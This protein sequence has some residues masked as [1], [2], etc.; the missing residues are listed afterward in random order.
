MSVRIQLDKPRGVFTNLDQ[1]SGVVVLS[2]LGPETISTITVKLEGESRSHLAGNINPRRNYDGFEKEGSRQEV[3]KLLY[4]VLTVFPTA[5]L[6]RATGPDQAYTLPSGPH[7]Y[8]F[9]FKLPFNNDCSN[10][11]SLLNGLNA[12]RFDMAR[13]TNNHVKKTLPPSLNGLP[14]EAEIL[15]YVKVTVQRPAFYKENFRAVYPFTFLPI[16]PPRAAANN[17]ESYARRSHQFSP[18]IDVPEKAGLFRKASVAANDPSVPEVPPPNISI[19][20]RLPDPAIITCNESLPLR[21]LIT[22]KNESPATIYLRTLSITLIGF[23]LIR[24]HDLQ[25][26]EA[27]SWV[28]LSQA[29][30]DKPLTSTVGGDGSKILEVESTLWKQCPLPSIVPPSFTTCNISRRYELEIKAGLAWGSSRNINPELSV[31]TVRMPVEVY[32]GIAPP[33]ALLDQMA[34]RPSGQPA[35]NSNLRPHGSV[36][37]PSARPTPGPNTPGQ[38]DHIEPSPSDIPDE[39]PPSYE[40]AMADDLAPI[41][42]P[43]RNYQQQTSSTPPGSSGKGSA[44]DDRLFPESGR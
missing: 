3:H 4:K 5:E 12:L 13:D 29:H 24:A 8:P 16:E 43:R 40:D 35:T 33:Q 22:K 32:S 1:I 44:R 26:R 2:I 7:A 20:G 10:N 11:N 31:Q 36:N 28:I 17:R 34:N 14:G 19:D 23:T 42:G 9:Q 41:D 37:V 30:I 25:R 18:S 6:R 39:A 38:S 21:I 15:Y 27:Q